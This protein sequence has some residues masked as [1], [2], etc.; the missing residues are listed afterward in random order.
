MISQ[1]VYYNLNL[2]NY[3][4]NQIHRKSSIMNTY[5]CTQ[6]IKLNQNSLKRFILILRHYLLMLLLKML[7][8]KHLDSCSKHLKQQ[9]QHPKKLKR[10]SKEQIAYYLKRLSTTMP[11]HWP[12]SKTPN[13][14]QTML[15]AWLLRYLHQTADSLFKC[16][17]TNKFYSTSF[18]TA[19]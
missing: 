13:P 15:L 18:R 3:K 12:H 17:M 16:F 10:L 9:Q 5:Y 14:M 4:R 2:N 19:V 1:I 8:F 11:I 7:R 6:N